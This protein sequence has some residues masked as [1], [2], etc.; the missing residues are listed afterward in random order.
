MTAARSRQQD[1][2]GA[3]AGVTLVEVLVAILLTVLIA[4]PVSAWTISTLRQQRDARSTLSNATSTGSLNSY[5]TADVASARSVAPTGGDCVGGEGG[6]GTV[7]MAIVAGGLDQTRI[8]YS[9]ARPQGSSP[10][11]TER[12]LWRRVCAPDG[13]TAA[14][15]EVFESMLPGSVS[16]QCPNTTVPTPTVAVA[17]DTPANRR[18]RLSV[19]PSGPGG[20]PAPVQV[21]ATRRANADSVGV[22]G[23]GNRPPLAQIAVTPLVGY[24]NVPFSFSAGEAEDLDGVIAAYD[25]E[26]PSASGTVERSGET[27]QHSFTDVGEQT[28]LLRVTDDA[29]STNIA[30]VTVRVVNRFPVGAIS[31]GPELGIR[32]VDEFTFDATG[33]VDP[34]DPAEVLTYE[35]D[36][37][38]GLGDDRYQSGKVVRFVFPPTTDKGQRQVTLRVTDSLGGTD[39]L[40]RAVGLVDELPDPNGIVIGPEPVLTAG[41]APRVGSVG[42]SLPPLVVSFSRPPGAEVNAGDRWQLVRLVTGVELAGSQ[43]AGFTHSFGPGDAGEYQV[44]LLNAD[45]EPITEPRVFRVNAAPSASF[46]QPPG[47]GDA[48]RAVDFSSG[49]STDPDGSVVAWRWNFGFFES[50]TSTTSNPTHVFTDPG[51]YTVRL[52]VTDD[53][54]AV[55]EVEQSV[56]VTGPIPAPVPPSWAGSS[57]QIVAIPGA[58]SYRVSLVCDGVPADPGV[59][60]LAPASAP[61]LE[62]PEGVCPVPA[63]AVATVAVRKLDIWSAPSAPGVRP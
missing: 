56:V 23:S 60:D 16:L 54:G 49:A 38:P 32:G 30:A 20:A 57:I 13:T 24:V 8:V 10:G 4:V 18:V 31:V 2:V 55:T 14:A 39:T 34:D 46:V 51:R 63:T 3:Q 61:R 42:A 52:Q 40:V 9:E 37:G 48:P 1:S 43:A 21:L 6:S 33:S 22:P 25:W 28:V 53:D 62:L 59:G 5:F 50:W 26:F 29:G 7:R 44:R 45:G 17:C 11:S 41:K 19:T 36:L 35:W 47:A 12:S 27:V 15:T 58:E